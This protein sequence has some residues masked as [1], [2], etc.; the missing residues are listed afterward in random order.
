MKKSCLFKLPCVFAL[1]FFSPDVFAQNAR[2]YMN[3]QE[4][5]P[6]SVHF[7]EAA[8]I[9]SINFYSGAEAHEK[10]NLQT[11]GVDSVFVIF[12][13]DLS[14][15]VSYYQLLD[16]FHLD[17]RA[18]KLQLHWGSPNHP[19]VN[20]PQSMVFNMKFVRDVTVIKQNANTDCVSMWWLGR[21]PYY[22][23]AGKMLT[24]LQGYFENLG[25][26]PYYRNFKRK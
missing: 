4:I 1:L 21:N 8:T 19:Y 6:Q 14:D 17:K 20:D 15:V 12:K 26:N 18:R 22:T 5:A 11:Q 9:D 16:L 23:N 2:L 24:W 25:N 13:K 3:K 10:L 7:L